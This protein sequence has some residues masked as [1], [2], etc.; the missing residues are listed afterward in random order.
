MYEKLPHRV[1][2]CPVAEEASEDSFWL[3]QRA[4]MGSVEDTLDIARATLKI[5]EALKL[6]SS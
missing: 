4:L 3:P 6:T 1:G 5:H 2:E